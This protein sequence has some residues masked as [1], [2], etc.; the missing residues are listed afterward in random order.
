M[1]YSYEQPISGSTVFTA[2]DAGVPHSLTGMK[3]AKV[4]QIQT[5]GEVTFE[6]RT[7][8]QTNWISAGNVAEFARYNISG[9]TSIRVTPV[10]GS[11]LVTMYGE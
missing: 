7:G 2:E 10:S 3:A 1:K 4:H 6:F 5:D 11:V 9:V 8:T